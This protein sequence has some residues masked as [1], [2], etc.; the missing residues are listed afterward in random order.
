[1]DFRQVGIFCGVLLAATPALAFDG[2]QKNSKGEATSLYDATV[3]FEF[4]TKWRLNILMGEPVK[5]LV[6]KWRFPFDA[7]I[8]GDNLTSFENYKTRFTISDLPKSIQSTIRIYDVKVKVGFSEISSQGRLSTTDVTFDAGIPAKPGAEWSYN[9]P[10]SPAWAKFATKPGLNSY[11]PKEEAKAFLKSKKLF[12]V[13]AQSVSAKVK[14]GEALRW[15][16]KKSDKAPLE[17][18]L[19]GAHRH[20]TVIKTYAGLPVDDI[21]LEFELLKNQLGRADSIAALDAVRGKLVVSLK[22]LARGVPEHY[23]VPSLKKEYETAKLETAGWVETQ[24]KQLNKAINNFDSDRQKYDQWVTH[25][26]AE[27]GDALNRRKSILSKLDLQ[28]VKEAHGKRWGYKAK[29]IGQWVISPR[30]LGAN[31]FND[32]GL[33][34]VLL[35]TENRYE[36]VKIRGSCGRKSYWK[37]MDLTYYKYANINKSGDQVGDA[38]WRSGSTRSALVLCSKRS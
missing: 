38:T 16:R 18:M 19:T 34:S 6:I 1:M 22:N 10:G 12:G 21:E 29:D 13:W 27:L 3:P 24:V 20:L 17:Y 8:V 36:N 33:A 4:D 2:I 11:L 15:L 9:V 31:R 35:A 5:N 25:K 28:P 14:L 26:K 23:L 32:K 37:K 7:E 30:F